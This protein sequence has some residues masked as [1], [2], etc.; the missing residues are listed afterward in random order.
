M[1]ATSSGYQFNNLVVHGKT[2]LRSG[3]HG[4]FQ[5]PSPRVSFFE[6]RPAL[7]RYILKRLVISLIT[8]WLIA[9]YSFFLLHALPGTPFGTTQLMSQERCGTI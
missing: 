9:T 6:R 8:I 4:G 7:K 2:V 3:E 5:A 1:S